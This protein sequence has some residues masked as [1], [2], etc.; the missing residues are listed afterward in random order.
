MTCS[1]PVKI[2]SAVRSVAVLQ[3]PLTVEVLDRGDAA[4]VSVGTQVP[5]RDEL[6]QGLGELLV[7]VDPE[8]GG[9]VLRAQTKR[10]LARAKV[11]SRL[12]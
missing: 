1:G 7:G 11:R 3:G 4:G 9:D 8:F 6:L 10:S 2:P 5:P 12:R